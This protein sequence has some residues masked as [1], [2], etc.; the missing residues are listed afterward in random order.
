MTREQREIMWR[1]RLESYVPGQVGVLEWCARNGVD[2]KTF[3]YWRRRLQQPS[4][5]EQESQ[6][7]TV[8]AVADLDPSTKCE[9][10]PS[11]VSVR[12]GNAA[13]DLD[14]GFDENVLSAVVRVLEAT[15]C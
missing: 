11:G 12:I 10:R 15:R 1:Q 4:T 5:T 3:Y 6:W 7:L 14:T 9:P 8:T 2:R 13:I